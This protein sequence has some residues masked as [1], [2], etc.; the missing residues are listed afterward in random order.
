MLGLK[1]KASLL[2][3]VSAGIF[4]G[5]V[6]FGNTVARNKIYSTGEKHPSVDA[7]QIAESLQNAI[8]ETAPLPTDASAETTPVTVAEADTGTNLTGSLVAFIGRTILDRNP[9]GPQNGSINVR[10]ANTIAEEAMTQSINTTDLAGFYPILSSIEL[11]IGSNAQWTEHVQIALRRHISDLKQKKPSES[12]KDDAR[13][14]LSVYENTITNVRHITTPTKRIAE[15]Q[16]LLSLLTGERYAL[17]SVADYESDPIRGMVA[18]RMLPELEL[19]LQKTL[20]QL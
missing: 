13:A 3:F 8:G 16:Q 20:S 15:Q 12:F 17:Q 2:F 9:D 6:V 5:L 14:A 7:P 18:L 1:A 19:K 10:D 4:T 11:T